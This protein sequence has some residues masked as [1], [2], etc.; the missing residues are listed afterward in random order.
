MSK[1]HGPLRRFVRRW[2]GRPGLIPW[3]LWQPQRALL[4]LLRVLPESWVA[5]IVG[6]LGRLAWWSPRR[7][8]V[9][10]ENLA[11]AMPQLD[12]AERDRIL[13]ASCRSLG[14]MGAE[15]LVFG[16]RL[17]GG[18][19]SARLDFEPGAEE[20]LRRHAAGPA[21]VIQPH[22][23]S[24]E[25]GAAGLCVAGMQPAF[26]MRMP[27]NWYVAQRLL[28]HRSAWDV[29]VL[30][31]HGALRPML[32]QLQ[33]GKQVVL[34]TDQSAHQ[35]PIQ[36]PWFGRL[37]P[38]ERAAAVLAFRTG[39]AVLVSWCYRPRPG[40]RWQLG[41]RLIEPAGPARQADEAAVI[42]LLSR[43]HAALEEAILRRP[44]QYLWIHDR[45]R[46]RT[47]PATYSDA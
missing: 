41:A 18:A 3:L 17:H 20:L 16:P 42:E 11:Q 4:A 7:R 29:T 27:S 35:N 39:A 33:Q 9:G 34:A 5:G 45:Y 19:F 8:A 44:E 21:I 28:A 30:E 15:A 1:R 47:L 24:F 31:R 32:R 25:L 2:K 36:V 37:A 43:V 12:A 38:T 14:L 13:K 6:G 46:T 10:R 23:G 26:P 40:G 22:L